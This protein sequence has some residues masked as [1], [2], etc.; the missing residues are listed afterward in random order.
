V[1]LGRGLEHMRD[2]DG[3]GYGRGIVMIP[4][5]FALV[6]AREAAHWRKSSWKKQADEVR[7]SGSCS[8]TFPSP[9]AERRILGP[10]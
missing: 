10:E 9:F 8:A 3:V 5:R 1:Y 2:E 4:L 6:E 7:T